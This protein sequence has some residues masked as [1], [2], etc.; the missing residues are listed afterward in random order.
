M[1]LGAVI[2]DFYGTLTEHTSVT[3]RRSGT[4]GVARA[5]G[6][7]TDELFDTISSTFTERATGAA[8]TCSPP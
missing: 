6:I 7:P 4:N 5:L 2:F 3:V 1:S 8:A